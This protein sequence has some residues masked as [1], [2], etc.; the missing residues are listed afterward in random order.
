[1]KMKMKTKTQKYLSTWVTGGVER[2]DNVFFDYNAKLIALDKECYKL[3]KE[4]RES[5]R[6]HIF[7]APWY[8]KAIPL[9]VKFLALATP[10]CEQAF[11]EHHEPIMFGTSVVPKSN[12][13]REQTFVIFDIDTAYAN[14]LLALQDWH[15]DIGDHRSE[16]GFRGALKQYNK[17]VTTNFDYWTKK[18][19]QK[20]K[21]KKSS[22]KK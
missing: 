12:S 10:Y 18:T 6:E 1:M 19:A 21:A 7:L 9:H 5:R 14:T 13:T 20:K 16:V 11:S 8:K 4:Y 3:R 17:K 15:H 2:E 22:G